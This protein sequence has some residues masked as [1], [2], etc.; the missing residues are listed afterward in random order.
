MLLD[1]TLFQ[2]LK[3]VRLPLLERDFL[4]AHV[5][6]E[7]LVRASDSCKELLLEAMKYHLLPDQR[8][9]LTTERTAA[10]QPEGLEPYLF[11]IGEDCRCRFSARPPGSPG[12]LA[13]CH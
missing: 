8:A 4:M 7:P 11:A 10:R 12:C 6:C 9:A 13:R 2:L 3:H 1:K 5:D